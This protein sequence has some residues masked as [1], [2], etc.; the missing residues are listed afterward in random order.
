M[1]TDGSWSMSRA[2]HVNQSHRTTRA[3]AWRTA[4]LLGHRRDKA[5]SSLPHCGQPQALGRAPLPRHVPHG[6]RRRQQHHGYLYANTTVYQLTTKL[7]QFCNFIGDIF[8]TLPN[9]GSLPKNITI[10]V[11]TSWAASSA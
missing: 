7:N 5:Q 10:T 4:K 6:R 9:I 2:G 8:T 1:R 3:C 11:Y